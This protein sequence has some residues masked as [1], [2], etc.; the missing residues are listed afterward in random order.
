MQLSYQKPGIDHPVYGNVEYIVTD[1]TTP[2]CFKTADGYRP[3]DATSASQ[4][5][6]TNSAPTGEPLYV[7]SFKVNDDAEELTFRSK[8]MLEKTLEL[9]AQKPFITEVKTTTLYTVKHS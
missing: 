4:S 8:K 9:Y 2:L 7:L 6:Q 3:L 1:G 5:V